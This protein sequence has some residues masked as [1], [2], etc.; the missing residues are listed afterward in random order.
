MT[1]TV[2]GT[3]GDDDTLRIGLRYVDTTNKVN[4]AAVEGDLRITF[5]G[6]DDSE[7]SILLEDFDVDASSLTV[8]GDG[9]L[10]FA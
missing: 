8:Q 7:F 10:V 5:S 4:L 3:D 2:R 6:Y 1:E 9:W